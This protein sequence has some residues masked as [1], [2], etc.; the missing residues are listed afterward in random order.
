M[1]SQVAGAGDGTDSRDCLFAWT[2]TQRGS[3]SEA[4]PSF[5]GPGLALSGNKLGV[6]RLCG[7]DGVRVTGRASG[8]GL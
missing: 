6:L 4:F 1:P 2:K 8:M 3:T 7:S 5:E